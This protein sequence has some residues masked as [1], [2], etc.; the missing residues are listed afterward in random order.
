[1]EPDTVIGHHDADG[2]LAKIT[3]PPSDGDP[4]ITVHLGRLADGTN[5]GTSKFVKV[6]DQ[7]AAVPERLAVE[8]TE[9]DGRVVTIYATTDTEGRPEPRTVVIQRKDEDVLDL[10]SDCGD[11]VSERWVEIALEMFTGITRGIISAADNAGDFDIAAERELLRSVRTKK[12]PGRTPPDPSKVKE[13]V[14]LRKAGLSY[15]EI[16]ESVG[17]SKSTVSDWIKKYYED[18]LA[19]EAAKRF[20]EE[21]RE[22]VTNMIEKSPETARLIAR[23]LEKTQAGKARRVNEL[24]ENRQTSSARAIER[25]VEEARA[26]KARTL[27]ELLEIHDKGTER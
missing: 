25:I 16:A 5:L 7:V 22:S 6:G 19:E 11:R 8:V 24:L 15:R 18:N 20:G 1:M 4:E 9:H 17:S 21:S 23:T 14:R 3:R 10:P 12:R 13:A 27:E 2:L 26:S